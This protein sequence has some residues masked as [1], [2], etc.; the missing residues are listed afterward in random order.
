[1]GGSSETKSELLQAIKS[2][3]DVLFAWSMVTLDFQ[4]SAS[5]KCG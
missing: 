5:S 3:E 1:M 2:D 4:L